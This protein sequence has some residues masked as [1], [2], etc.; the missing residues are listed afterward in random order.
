M[1]HKVLNNCLKNYVS[2]SDV[3]LNWISSYL[4]NRSISVMLGDASSSHA[5]LFCG[6]KNWMS[7]NVL[8]LNDSRS[9]VI[10]NTPSGHSTSSI[11]NFS[12]SLGALSN[13]VKKRPN[14]IFDLE[15][16]FDVQVTKVVQSCFVQ[17][18]HLTQIK[19]FFSSAGQPCFY[20][21]QPDHC[22]RTCGMTLLMVP[23]CRLVTKCGAPCL[24]ILGTQTQ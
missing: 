8:R 24:G 5:P 15:L 16:P 21:L 6:V 22:L 20:L 2:I 1:D 7:K 11:S 14:V 10:I 9:E 18:R 23:K 3:A 17:L 12:S 19:P 4:L 13:N